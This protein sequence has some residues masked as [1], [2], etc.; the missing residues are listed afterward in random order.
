MS[1]QSD[2]T[3]PLNGY[4]L[5]IGEQSGNTDQLKLFKQ[6]GS[7]SSEI[8]ATAPGSAL[9]SGDEVN[10]RIRVTRDNLGNWEILADKEGGTNLVSLGT[11]NDNT[12]NFSLFS[13]VRIK[14]SSTRS[15]GFFFFDDFSV[16]G[17]GIMDSIAPTVLLLDVLSDSSLL[18]EFSE[19]LDPVTV[20]DNTSYMVNNGI[21]LPVNVELIS[22]DEVRLTFGSSFQSGVSY[23]I[24]ISGVSDLSDNVMETVTLPFSYFETV[25]AAF[26]DVIITEIHAAP[27]RFYLRS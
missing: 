20:L 14:Y 26:N 27:K 8:L 19:A 1:D 24:T 13:G 16:T 9:N 15:E 25:P 4:Y 3:G 7:N 10:V 18:I 17:E 21:N 23:E 5:R 12:Y 22:A 11:V 6:T 2:L